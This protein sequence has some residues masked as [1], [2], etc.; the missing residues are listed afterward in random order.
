MNVI[1]GGAAMKLLLAPFRKAEENDDETLTVS[2][3]AS[4]ESVDAA[5]EIVKAAA[6]EAALPSFRRFPAL[7]EMHQSIAAG[8]VTDI[9]VEKG[10]TLIEA[11]VVDKSSIAKIRHGVLRAFSIGG[12]A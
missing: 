2:G 7:R 8:K 4:T 3:I 5:G 10:Q 1:V 6:I 11:V 9:R 12:G